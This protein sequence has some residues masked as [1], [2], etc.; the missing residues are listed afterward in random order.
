MRF[1]L[2]HRPAYALAVVHIDPG[3][4]VVAEGGAM[5][6][7]STNVK[8]ETSAGKKGDGLLGGLMKGLKR[9]V[10]GE[11]FFQNR[12]TAEGAP[13][14]VTFAPTHQGDIEVYELK[15]NTMY[16][17]STAFVCSA[18][19]VEI[20]AKWGGSRTFF[21][22]EGL[23]M[24]KAHGTGPIAFNSFGGIKEVD[25][26]GTFIVDTGHIVAFEETVNF[27]VS[28]FGGGWK[29][30]IFGGEG[31]VCT[32]SGTG[33]VWLQTRNANAFGQLLGQ[34]LPPRRG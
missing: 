7:M 17:Q 19:T 24:L 28:R 22:G 12:F 23:V 13:G 34:K 31:L 5:V 29:A 33:K 11:S 1:D 9:M 2:E 6:S 18:D 27:K 10:A 14:E 3:E 26:D 8:M 32:F 20:D 21:G 15:G 30:F 25:I 4:T 16:L